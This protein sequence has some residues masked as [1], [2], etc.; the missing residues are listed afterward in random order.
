MKTGAHGTAANRVYIDEASLDRLASRITP[1]GGHRETL[2]VDMPFTGEPLGRVPRCTAEDVEAA[3]GLARRAQKGW[4]RTSFEERANIFLRFHDLVLD[5][6]SEVLDLIQLENGKA[7]KHAFEEVLDTAI[8]AR[9]YANTTRKHLKPRRR[10]GA[11]PLLTSTRE[12]HH[13]RG[14]A[15]FIAPWNYPL[16]LGIT[17]AIPALLAGNGALIKPDEKTPYSALWAVDLLYEAGLPHDL[18]QVVTGYGSELGKP[19]VENADFVM[20]TGST[21]VG[22]I[23]AQQAAERL[24][25]CSMELGG[26]NAMIVLEDADLD[27]AVHGAERAVFSSGGQ[28]CIAMERIY[29]HAEIYDE[30]KRRFVERTR[31]MKL[32]AGLDY[33]ADMGSIVSGEHLGRIAAH[34]RDAVAKGAK[35]LAGGHPRPDIGPYFYE[36]TVL[37]NVTGDMHLCAEETFGPVAAL[38]RFY[39]VDEAVE[40]ANESHYGLNFSVWTRNTKK[41]R[42]LA[43]RLQA[44]TVNVNEAYAAAWGSVDAPMG[45][46]KDSGAGRRHGAYGIRKYTESQT[47]AV[48]RGFAAAAPPGMSEERYAGLTTR[49]LKV[50]RRLPGVR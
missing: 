29:V 6:Q 16:T 12:Y 26:K 35:L 37:E 11:I 27:R 2:V 40:Q 17:D 4:S 48:Q 25:D 24:I 47:V 43:T 39:T 44:G 38:Y 30:F 36:P 23:V 20:F 49:A 32:G 9:Y 8:I 1:T 31:D 46:F 21:S 19:I 7:R 13:P 10:R 45:G 33:G 42:N 22:R 14:V 5:R 41:G 28:L 15:A 3:A 50:L 34:V 18:T